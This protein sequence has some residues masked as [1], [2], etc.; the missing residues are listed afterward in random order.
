MRRAAEGTHTDED[1]KA[2][3]AKQGGKCATCRKNIRDAY[4]V[5]HVMPLSKGGSNGPDNLQ[6]LCPTCNRKKSTKR[7]DEWAQENGRL[8]V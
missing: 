1:I 2:L 6:L 7:P 8:F 5:D 3:F 4:D